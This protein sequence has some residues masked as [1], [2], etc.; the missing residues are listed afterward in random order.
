MSEIIE[1]N[2][3][4]KYYKT[5]KAVDDISFNVEK[6]ELFGFL[7]VNGAGKSTTI[8]ML[9][10][11]LKPTEGEVYLG[12]YKLGKED[13]AIRRLIGVVYQE[14]SLDDKL[15]VAEN[16]MIRGSLYESSRKCLKQQMNE[17]IELLGLE[18]IL[19]RRFKRLSGGQKR[20]CEIARALMHKPEI[21]FLDEPTTGLDPA[22][23]KDV[24]ECVK[25][26][27]EE[28]QMTV[29]LTT[30]YMEE[31]A[32]ATHIAIMDSG[33]LKQ[34][35]TPFSLK[36]DFANDSLRLIP[37]ELGKIETLLKD[38]KIEFEVED[39]SLKIK[40]SNTLAAIDLVADF[41]QEISGFEVVQGSMDDV[42]LKVTGK[43]LVG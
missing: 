31:A 14:N 34:Y 3:L 19:N 12:G 7:G 24:W 35:G 10:T 28:M 20:R 8:N 32:T 18:D 11:L 16:L 25:K 15:T 33:K 29:F 41:R 6:G 42:F 4:K 39:K 40:L 27:R 38:K 26:L 2:H 22:T 36:E 30:H 23:R 13:E 43:V 5:V 9:C 17:V 37:K 21:L 1:V